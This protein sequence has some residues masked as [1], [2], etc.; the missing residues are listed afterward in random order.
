MYICTVQYSSLGYVFG[1]LY[2]QVLGLALG[3]GLG[4]GLGL[5]LA[6]DLG[7]GLGPGSRGNSQEK[8]LHLD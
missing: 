5:G 7:L 1:P 2:C 4:L 3:V 6:L 8:K